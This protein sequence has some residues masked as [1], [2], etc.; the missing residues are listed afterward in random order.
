MEK[1][2]KRY[3]DSNK[4]P[5]Q[6]GF[7]FLSRKDEILF[8]GKTTNLKQSLENL[9]A[10]SKNDKEIFQLLS[11]TETISYQT[12]TSLF[13]ALLEEKKIL[14]KTHPRFNEMIKQYQ[15]YVYFAVDF[16]N[17]PFLKI[18][19]DTSENYFYLGPFANRFFLYDFID[20]MADVLKLPSCEDEN[21]P[22]RKLKNKTCHGWCLKDNP[23]TAVMLLQ[24]YLLVND[25]LLDKL[26]NDLE[27]LES[28]LEFEPA[29]ILKNQIKIINN[30]YDKLK[31]LHVIKQ[32]NSKLVTE[33]NT[34]KISSGMIAQIDNSQKTYDFAI[35]DA[36]YRD[37]EFLAHDKSEFSE[38]FLVYN[39]IYKNNL[40]Q[41]NSLYKASASK[42][43]K[44]LEMDK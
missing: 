8:C 22:C 2:E 43:K 33:D 37:N 28:N 11:L 24:N 6:C 40:G 44:I 32:L 17:V 23:E 3:F 10:A 38:R 1:I 12:T 25:D 34:V 13:T 35:W 5:E 4:I 20:T 9:N 21:Y 18:T 36:D 27:K 30:Y 29:E 42:M 19:E 26:K 15:N 31:F 39:E 7:Y 14:L 41:I 16:Y